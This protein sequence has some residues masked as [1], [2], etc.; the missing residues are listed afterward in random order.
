MAAIKVELSENGH[1]ILK[2]MWR[3]QKKKQDGTELTTEEKNYYNEHLKNAQ[4]HYTNQKAYYD[5]QYE[6]WN[7]QKILS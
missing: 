7:E 5:V 3:I 6:L 1:K 4:A 2:E